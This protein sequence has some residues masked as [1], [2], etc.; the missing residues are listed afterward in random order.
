[1]VNR[2]SEG[3]SSYGLGQGGEMISEWLKIIWRDPV[4]SKL[5]SAGINSGGGW[6]IGHYRDRKAAEES[7]DAASDQIKITY[8]QPGEILSS[9]APMENG[10]KFYVWGALK[11]KPQDHEVWILIQDDSGKVW[12]QCNAAIFD[13]GS[14]TWSGWINPGRRSEVRIVAVVAPPTS[15]IFSQYFQK[16]GDQNR[17]RVPLGSSAS[18]MY[19]SGFGPR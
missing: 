19:K 11:G 18:G 5:I 8:P 13:A 14:R 15:H 17:K 7:E 1:L 16:L 12:P 2:T 4:W 9:G 6:L 3:G 10:R